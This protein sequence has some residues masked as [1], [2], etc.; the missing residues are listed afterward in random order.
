MK[1]SFKSKLEDAS[2]EY[3]KMNIKIVILFSPAATWI[4]FYSAPPAYNRAPL[5]RL[6]AALANMEK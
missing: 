1:V 6:L 2:R 5:T 4:H 3:N